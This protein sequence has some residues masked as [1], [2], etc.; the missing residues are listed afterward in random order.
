MAS[1]FLPPVKEKLLLKDIPIMSLSTRTEPKQILRCNNQVNKL[2]LSPQWNQWNIQPNDNNLE[3]NTIT[4][5]F[6]KIF[7]PELK[8]FFHQAIVN[9]LPTSLSE[10]NGETEKEKNAFSAVED[11]TS[12]GGIQVHKNA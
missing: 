6:S 5:T 2:H 12:S 11:F 3:L 8:Q 1:T 9:Y 10:V 7:Q 4:S